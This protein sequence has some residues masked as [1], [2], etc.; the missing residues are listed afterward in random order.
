MSIWRIETLD[1]IL[2]QKIFITS[3]VQDFINQLWVYSPETSYV[4]DDASFW[5]NPDEESY[6]N[7]E[8]AME[9]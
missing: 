3:E 9:G 1:K 5:E 2:N 6:A 8:N 4:S 7:L